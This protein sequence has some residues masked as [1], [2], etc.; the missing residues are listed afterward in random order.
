MKISGIIRFWETQ[1]KK[2]GD[3]EVF[4]E[5]G[6]GRSTWEE[7]YTPRLRYV[8]HWYMRVKKWMT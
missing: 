6:D 5:C 8:K 4:T 3:V 7:P 2:Q 1:L